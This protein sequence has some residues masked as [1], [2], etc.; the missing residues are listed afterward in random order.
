LWF[1]YSLTTWDELNTPVVLQAKKDWIH[2]TK[3][4]ILQKLSD[5]GFVKNEELE[6]ALPFHIERIDR[7]KNDMKEL[8]N[9]LNY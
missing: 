3:S 9:S 7:W 8:L 2:K 6:L 4:E 1:G 5:L